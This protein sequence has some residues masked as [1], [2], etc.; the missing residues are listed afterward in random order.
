VIISHTDRKPDATYHKEI[1][2]TGVMLE[3]DS[4]FRWGEGEGN[5]TLALVLTMFAE[6]FGRQILLG[7]DAA[8]K[9]YWRAGGGSPG[10]RFLLRD[11]VPRLQ[12]GGLRQQDIDAIF[13]HNPKRCYSFDSNLGFLE[14]G[15]L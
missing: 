10:L 2:S 5:P 11:F 14:D 4:A 1:L 6:G 15:S 12:S 7:M 9:K 3:Y 13:I 8:R